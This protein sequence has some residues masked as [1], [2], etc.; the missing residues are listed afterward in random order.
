MPDTTGSGWGRGQNGS[1]C[2]RLQC[3]SIIWFPPSYG[4]FC[5]GHSPLARAKFPQHPVRLLVQL[6]G[7]GCLPLGDGIWFDLF[8]FFGAL[9]AES[10]GLQSCCCL[11]TQVPCKQDGYYA[12][13]NEAPCFVHLLYPMSGS[14]DQCIPK[15]VKTSKLIELK[16]ILANEGM[17]S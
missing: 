9:G 3:H 4:S 13:Q 11:W 14:A 1:H 8:C 7:C 15:G 2:T 12:L 6:G 16:C 10:D 17:S 5:N